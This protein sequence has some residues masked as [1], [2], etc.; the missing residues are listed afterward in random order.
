MKQRAPRTIIGSFNDAITRRDLVGLTSLMTVDHTFIE[1]ANGSV[2]GK[3]NCKKAWARFF[4]SFP[5]YH[6]I[7]E[8]ISITGDEA[9][10]V[11]RSV[12]T[13]NRLAGPALWTAKLTGDLIS[14]WRVYED[15]AENRQLLGVAF[16][17]TPTAPVAAKSP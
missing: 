10:I 5:D 11:G 12:C 7:F 4:A 14:E 6:N 17:D 2:I 1:S 9:V 8:R 3:Q 13:D 15:T 16:S